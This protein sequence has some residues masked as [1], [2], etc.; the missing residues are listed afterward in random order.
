MDGRANSIETDGMSSWPSL[1]FDWAAA[2]KEKEKENH[3]SPFFFFFFFDN[4]SIEKRERVKE[5]AIDLSLYIY[6]EGPAVV[7]ISF[8]EDY[9][10][11][12]LLAS[13]HLA[14]SPSRYKYNT[15]SHH[16]S[17]N[18]GPHGESLFDS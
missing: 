7:A 11:L 17:R 3:F 6:I 5:R 4:I 13:R 12:M 10:L 15:F 16:P 18:G 1:V 2:R 9:E 14:I 8:L